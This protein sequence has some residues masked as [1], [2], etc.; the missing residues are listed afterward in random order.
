LRQAD[1]T[2]SRFR[3]LVLRHFEFL[4]ARG[5]HRAPED[6]VES[7][8]GTSVA[9]AG[10]HVGFLVSWDARDRRVSVRVAR[11]SK[12]RLAMAGPEGY[13]RDL[14]MHAIEREGYRGKGVAPAA[15][16]GQD[17]G[18][19]DRELQAWAAFLRDEAGRLLLDRDDEGPGGASV[20]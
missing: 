2:A 13:S 11:V 18:G 1:L 16:S 12:G 17:D 15:S 8:V 20:R 3:D 4:E 5:F 19:I 9:F 10:R 14:L 6:E 7:S